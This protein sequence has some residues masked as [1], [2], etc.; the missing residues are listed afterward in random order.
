MGVFTRPGL[1]IGEVEFRYLLGSA[2][3]PIPD[4]LF[5]VE[6]FNL[7]LPTDACKVASDLWKTM[8]E[9]LAAI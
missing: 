9:L 3:A 4:L 7:F 5:D 2:Q 1:R 6:E 8:I